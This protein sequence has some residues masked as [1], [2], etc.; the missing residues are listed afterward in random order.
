MGGTRGALIGLVTAGL[1][2][3]SACGGDDS[4]S[5][6]GEVTNLDD[7]A[8]A[9]MRIDTRGSLVDPEVGSFEFAGG[10][11]SGFFIDPSGL[12]VT[13][14]HVVTGVAALE[15]YVGDEDEP[16]SA[17]V[18]G[19]SEC[20]DLAVIDVEGDDF[21]YLD[22]YAGDIDAGLDIYAAGYPD[23]EN[24]YSVTRGVVVNTEASGDMPWASIDSMV[25]H[26][27]ATRPGSSGG[28]IVTEDGQVVAVHFAAGESDGGRQQ[29]AISRDEALPILDELEKGTD[30]LSLGVNG[31]AVADS[32]T[33]TYGVWVQSV[34]TGSPAGKLGL[35]GGDI[36]TKMEGLT[37]AADG[38]MKDYCDILRSHSPGDPLSVQ[39]LRYS[40]QEYLTGEFY[41]NPLVLQSS[42][43]DQ[44]EQ[45]AGTDIETGAAYTDYVLITDD[46]GALQVEVPV[47]WN[48]VNTYWPWTAADGT[49]TGT[50]IVASPSVDDF[51]NDW[52]TPGVA[53]SVGTGYTPDELLDT[54]LGSDLS[55]LDQCD[56]GERGDYDDGLYT[57][58]SQIFTQCGETGAEYAVIAAEPQGGEFVILVE[59]QVVTQADLDALDRILQT[60]QVVGDIEGGGTASDG[61]YTDW[62]TLTDDYGA[63]QVEVPA[64]WDSIDSFYPFV[65]KDTGDEVGTGVAAAPDLSKFYDTWST[66]G[67]S[68]SAESTPNGPGSMD[69]WLDIVI[70]EMGVFGVCTDDGRSD[71]DDG[72]YQ[73]RMHSYSGCG[74]VG[75]SYYLI[76][77]TTEARDQ[78]M[79]VKVQT[80]TAADDEALERIL[81]SFQVVGDIPA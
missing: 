8:D 23:P 49:Q 76:A 65:T 18:V 71:Y 5:A 22:W 52:G 43:G 50:G 6:K 66:P 46:T 47:E 21:P 15:V 13:N 72:Y 44:I 30:V 17:R 69:E 51:F 19:V 63:V 40:T 42:F 37:L 45:D 26:D 1:L 32:E 77:A 3:G 57:G 61:A 75:A 56:A 78:A 54:M 58:R 55:F 59:V 31:I 36:I 79:M 39:V 2:L 62:V 70:E 73:G 80:V 67:M 9:M 64:A 34:S 14:N 35:Q 53:I 10:G 16:R 33:G 11:G 68:F 41:G 27:A 60:F 48:D 7:V 28:P 29:F 24:V 4:A 81:G 25:E 74:D 20:S 38:T 12:A